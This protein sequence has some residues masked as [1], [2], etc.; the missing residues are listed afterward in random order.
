MNRNK[1][2]NVFTATL[3][4]CMLIMGTASAATISAADIVNPDTDTVVDIDGGLPLPT[5]PLVDEPVTLSVLYKRDTAHG[6]FSQMWFIE[7]V[8]KQT[9]I[10]MEIMGIEGVGWTEKMNLSFASGDLPDIFLTGLT[11]SDAAKYGMAGQL[12]A[13]G[14]MIEQYAPNAKTLLDVVP[15]ARRNVTASD[16][17]IYYMPAYNLTARDM[18]Y[19]SGSINTTWLEALGI[20]SP[21]T[22]DEFYAA[23]VAIRD[24][25]VDGDGDP[26]NEI[27]MSFVFDMD[28][29]TCA[30]LAPL[31]AFGYVNH[32]HDVID[33]TY[34]YVPM[35]DN[36]REYLKFMNK[37]WQEG[38]LDSET[39]TQNADQYTAKI[40][41]YLLGVATP[42]DMHAQF[43]DENKKAA[44]SLIGPLTSEFNQTPCWI[45]QPCEGGNSFAVT[46][47]CMQ[48][49]AAVKLLDYFYSDVCSTMTK[50]GPEEGMWD[51]EG[52]WSKVENADGTISYNIVYDNEKYTGFWDFRCKNGL[53]YMPFVYG[54]HQ[55]AIVTGADYYASK[56]SE[57]IF[58]S[59]CYDARRDGYPIGIS[60]TEEEQGM[61]AMFVLLDDYVNRE[62]AS[63]ITG[64]KNVN[65]D[66]VW[67]DYIRS[68]QAMDVDTMIQ[69]RQQAYDRW[70]Q[71]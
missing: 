12:I 27:P 33:G 10:R 13:L 19:R 18:I 69:I 71:N 42:G 36:Y 3:C 46:N 38:L 50:C 57:M 5:L 66:A 29:Y 26:A 59:G 28:A 49:Q 7:E 22:L 68:I 9:G 70:A 55:A 39:F 8:E 45:A 63:F 1:F 32:R 21:K 24:N 15:D 61:L 16:G 37:L 31:S 14:D 23:L 34:V 11:A 6:D 25:D 54:S 47:T 67:D 52:G 51:G 17:N 2:L 35:Q 56:V 48:P 20:A 62:V 43:T 30:S 4:F 41:N 64:A 44:Y 58:S 65:D 40:Q 60:F 53:M